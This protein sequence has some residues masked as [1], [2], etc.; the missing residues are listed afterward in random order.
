[1]SLPPAVAGAYLHGFT[2]ERLT[3]DGAAPLMAAELFSGFPLALLIK[4]D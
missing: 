2:R 1:L 4:L 3:L